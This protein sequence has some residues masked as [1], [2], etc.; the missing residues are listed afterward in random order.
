MSRII[1]GIDIETILDPVTPISFDTCL[2]PERKMLLCETMES[3]HTSLALYGTIPELVVEAPIT[4]HL[5]E[6]RTL[7]DIRSKSFG[8]IPGFTNVL[9]QLEEA[10]LK[11]DQCTQGNRHVSGKMLKPIQDGLMVTGRPRHIGGNRGDPS[12]K[13]MQEEEQAL[14]SEQELDSEEEDPLMAK[15]TALLVKPRTIPKAHKASITTYKLLD[16]QPEVSIRPF[17]STHDDYDTGPTVEDSLETHRALISCF[18]NKPENFKWISM[19]MRFRDHGFRML[20]GSLD[21]FYLTIPSTR[22]QLAHFFPTAPPSV[23]ADWREQI[24][25]EP[26]DEDLLSLDA[27]AILP[28]SFIA[29]SDLVEWGLEEMMA[30]AGSENSLSS[31]MAY[32]AG[33]VCSGP[34]E[35]SYI[36]LDIMKDRVQPK[37]VAISVDIDSIIWLTPKL[38]VSGI[39]NLHTSPYRKE[40]APISTANHVYI[41]L[42]WPRLDEDV[43]NGG[44]SSGVKQ[45]PLCNLPNT[46]FATFGRLEGSATVA[47]VF[48]RM[49]HRYPL[50]RYW[51]TK[52]PQEVELLWLRD[53]VY[54]AL[55][56]LED[57]GI[58]PYMESTYEDTKWKHVGTQET[59]LVLAPEHLDQL[60]VHIDAILDEKV[61]HANYDCFRSYFFVLEMRGVKVPTS[62]QDIGQKNPWDALV[63]NYPGFDWP[64]MENTDNGELLVDIGV[65]FHPSEEEAVVG[66]WHIDLLRL[67]FDYGGYN[68]GTTHSVST[69]TCIGGIQAEMSKARRLKTHIAYRQAYNLSYEAIRGKLTRER[70]AFFTAES[71]YIYSYTKVHLFLAPG[72]PPR[73]YYKRKHGEFSR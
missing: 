39:I 13:A 54:V 30:E 3:I 32:V 55:H 12:R 66:F 2:H 61:G 57:N 63:G 9:R 46:H 52:F 11:C 20:S 71:A 22:D 7:E 38:K 44:I 49:K 69:V 51:E 67:A 37:E 1:K 23:V 33:R 8:S 64:Y 28:D 50:Q 35:G 10:M 70:K 53:V 6:Q 60:L 18:D 16:A 15:P 4:N 27:R 36:R 24:A 47:V 72:N 40:R 73:H 5:I 14:E 68:Q 29:G 41:E 21:Q 25:I 26:A 34:K 31:M 65:G 62:S 58:K 59:T 45:V 17:I 48:P 56:R 43:I 42:L 19:M